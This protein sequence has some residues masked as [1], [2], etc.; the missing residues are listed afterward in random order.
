YNG[1]KAI[2]VGD[3]NYCDFHPQLSKIN[4]LVNLF[5]IG[6]IKPNTLYFYHDLDVFQNEPITE[7]ELQLELGTADLGATDKGRMP[8]WNTGTLLFKSNSRD[9]FSWLK[10]ILFKYRVDEEHALWI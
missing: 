4:T 2:T 3:E 8:M 5:E 10:D 7:S 6:L 1:I 9:I